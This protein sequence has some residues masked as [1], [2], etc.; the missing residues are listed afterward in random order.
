MTLSDSTFARLNKHFSKIRKK[1]KSPK[2]W[3]I[4]DFNCNVRTA[5]RKS[6]NKFWFDVTP[7]LY[8]N[9]QVK[10]FLYV[11]GSSEVIYIS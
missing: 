3:I 5:S 1:S 2:I 9:N 7:S 11:C 4:D 8:E 6:R 10:F